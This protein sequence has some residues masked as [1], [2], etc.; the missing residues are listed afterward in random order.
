MIINDISQYLDCRVRQSHLIIGLVVPGQWYVRMFIIIWSITTA[1][2]LQN[3]LVALC[4]HSS[5]VQAKSKNNHICDI[6][7]LAGPDPPPEARK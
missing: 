4:P 5:P 6:D 7:I 2:P 1:I 3:S